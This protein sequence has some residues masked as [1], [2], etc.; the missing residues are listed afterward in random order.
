[1]IHSFLHIQRS[2]L[3]VIMDFSMSPD[4]EAFSAFMVSHYRSCSIIQF[5]P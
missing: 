4:P 3:Q 2:V 5:L 1:M